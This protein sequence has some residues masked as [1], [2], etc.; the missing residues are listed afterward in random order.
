MTATRED[1]PSSAWP[2]AARLV[3]RWLDQRERVDVLL[4]SLPRSLTGTPRARCQH[5]VLGAVRH[6]GRIDAALGRLVAHPPRFPTRAVLFIAGYELLENLD[7][8]GAEAE[9]R[10]PRIVHHAV[11]QTKALA[12][13]AEARLV[14]A[15]GRKLAAALARSAPAA[16][17]SAGELAE[18]FSHPD[19]LIRSWHSH[20]GAEATRTLLEWNQKPAPVYA[21]WRG[22]FELVAPAKPHQQAAEAEDAAPSDS[23]RPHGDAEPAATESPVLSGHLDA[24]V[25]PEF[26]KPTVWPGFFEVESGRWPE[27]EPLLKT[28]RI[29]LQDP[30]TRLAVEMIGPQSDET[31]LDLC[32]APG[33]KALLLA[34][35]MKTGRL[36]A[37]DLPGGRID[38][39]KQNLAR[40]GAVEVALVQADVL[41]GLG[42][43]L[44]EHRLPAT[45]DAVLLDVPCSNTGVMRH[46]VDVKWRLQPGDFKKHP[47]QQLSML[48]AAARLVSPTGR[49]VYSTCSIDAEENEHVVR[50]FLAGKAGGAFKLDATVL[51]YPWTDGHDGGAAFRLRRA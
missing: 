23:P 10:V 9:G 2:A 5:L 8:R 48:H 21:R 27:V 19:W 25:P 40:A 31:V 34:D 30:A 46:R 4:D 50:A 29:Y 13:P 49:L 11:E 20:F 26:L 41:Q 1:I 43:T 7:T 28:G 38:R 36:V 15:V 35:T 37:V 32:A 6:F 16:D 22:G 17:A 14:N 3:A 24:A 12:S 44:R 51:S 47:R 33:G 18:Y 39:L 42:A 45:Y